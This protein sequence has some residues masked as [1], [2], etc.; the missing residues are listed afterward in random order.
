MAVLLRIL[1][2]NVR[3]LRDDPAAVTRVIRSA[4]AHLVFVQ[5]APAYWRWGPRCA[6]LARKCGMVA[7]AGGGGGA[8]GNFLMS[9][10]AV[11]VHETRT[12]RLAHALMRPQRGAALARCSLL[13]AQFMAAGTHL[14]THADE[15][16]AQF[17]SLLA[18]LPAGGP[19]AII[20]GDMNEDHT[21]PAWR[22]AATRFTDA[23]AQSGAPTFSCRT[24]RR[25]IDAVFTD[26][27]IAVRS[28]QVLDSP[29]VR[30]ASDHF[31]VYAEL[32]LPT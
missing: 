20:A 16:S 9:T 17:A 24:P 8:F 26:P 1:S 31:P 6:A 18:A 21:G 3:S 32:E 14:A 30:K 13:G 25:R 29:D 4:G 23:G 12:F 10:V 28:Y 11:A 27:R 15:R 7:I 5:E 19:P 22:A 2:Y